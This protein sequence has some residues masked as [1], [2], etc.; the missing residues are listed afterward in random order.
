MNASEILHAI[1]GDERHSGTHMHILGSSGVGKSYF[2]EFLLRQ[3]VLSNRGFCLVDWHGTSYQRMLN[4]LTYIRPRRE[5]VLLNPSEPAFVVG[6]NPFIDPGDDITTTV[7]RRIDATI[8]PWGAV[9]TNQ[10]PT[11]ER[12]VRY[13]YHFAVRAGETLPNAQYLLRFNHRYVLDYALS[14]LTEPEDEHVR[15]EIAELKLAKSPREWSDK[16]LSTKNR[17]ARFI[18]HSGLECF[19]GLKTGNIRIRELVERNA[20]ILVNLARSGHIDTEPA[21]VFASLLIN[22]FREAAMRRAGT[23]KHYFLALDEFQEYVSFDLAPMLDETRKGGVHLILAH[24]RLGHLQ[25][26]EDLRDAVFSNCQ[27]KAVFGG[28]RYE[29]ASVMANEMYLDRINLRD[30]KETYYGQRVAGFSREEIGTESRTHSFH[31][32][33]NH[34]FDETAPSQLTVTSGKQVVM[35]PIYEDVVSGRAEWSREEKVSRMAEKLK[36][37]PRQ[38]CTIKIQ[39]NPPQEFDVPT[40]QPYEQGRSRIKGYAE[41]VYSKLEALTLKD[42]RLTVQ[43]S[44]EAFLSKARSARRPSGAPPKMKPKL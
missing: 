31:P 27:V 33:E 8:K 13:A 39:A 17:F 23:R 10:T 38:R 4:Y 9:N 5:V 24:Q 44:R 32:D 20:I 35:T 22:E 29:S 14:I 37:Q 28:L 43:K 41:G 42:A 18:G 40:L 6:F 21:K 15:E 19:L 25:R 36:V 16:V 34:H 12:T 11:L 1:E 3:A 2:L 30:V 7:A 26:D